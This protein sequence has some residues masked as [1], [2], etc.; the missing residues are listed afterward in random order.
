MSIKLAKYSTERIALHR[1]N[2]GMHGTINVIICPFNVYYMMR[3]L[4][5][6]FH[7]YL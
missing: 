6:P 5:V 1:D 7:H 2:S 3:T 4:F